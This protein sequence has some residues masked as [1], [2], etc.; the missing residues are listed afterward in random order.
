MKAICDHQTLTG[1]PKQCPKNI[2]EAPCT[3][4]FFLMAIP[5]N[6]TT[7]YTTNIRPGE[8]LQMDI[9]LYNV[10]SVQ[11]LTSMITLVCEKTRII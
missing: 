6:G 5:P 4:C 7:I 3:V 11:Y 1:L 10:T 2:N 8:I 9:T